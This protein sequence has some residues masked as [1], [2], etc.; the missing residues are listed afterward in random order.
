MRNSCGLSSVNRQHHG[1]LEKRIFDGGQLSI[2]RNYAFLAGAIRITHEFL[3]QFVGILSAVEEHVH[4]SLGRP[5]NN[6]KRKL[7][8]H[9]PDGPA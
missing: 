8:H 3:D 6:G 2:E 7:D 4:Q 1:L 5:Q 9:C